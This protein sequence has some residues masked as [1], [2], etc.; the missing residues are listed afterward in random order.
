MNRWLAL[1]VAAVAKFALL[2][3]A[4]TV[5]V[6]HPLNLMIAGQAQAIVVPQAIVAMMTWPQLLTAVAG[7]V[8]A[9]GVEFGSRRLSGKA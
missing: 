3:V 5:L 8:I 9:F 4:V 2:Y 1:V 7:G 6:A